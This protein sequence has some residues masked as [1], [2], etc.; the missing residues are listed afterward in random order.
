MPLFPRPLLGMGGRIGGRIGFGVAP[1][2][3]NVPKC[4]HALCSGRSFMPTSSSTATTTCWIPKSLIWSQRSWPR[5]LSWSLTRPTTLVS[6]PLNP[7]FGVSLS[8]SCITHDGESDAVP[9][10]HRQRLH[11]LHGGEHHAPDAG[12]LP[13]QCDHAPNH[14]PK[15]SVAPTS[16]PL[17]PSFSHTHP[18]G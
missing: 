2:S 6:N 14:H 8:V 5:S 11:R 18:P 15:V 10:P 16:P 13:G 1:L 7:I 12:P 3:L 9:Y 17:S 4:P